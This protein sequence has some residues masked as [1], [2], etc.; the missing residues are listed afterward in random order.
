MEN[1]PPNKRPPPPRDLILFMKQLK[2]EQPLLFEQLIDCLSADPS[3]GARD[4]FARI[5]LAALTNTP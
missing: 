2:E 3:Q 5:Q 4:I 1:H